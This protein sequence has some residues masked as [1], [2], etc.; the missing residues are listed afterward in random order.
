[1]SNAPFCPTGYGTVTSNICYRLL[2]EG[3]NVTTVNYWGHEG[4]VLTL[5]GLSQYPKAFGTFGDDAARFAIEDFKP[6]VFLTFFDVWVG[7]GWIDRL[8]PRWIPYMPVD[9]DPA[10]EGVVNLVRN[11]YR[12][13]AM[14][15]YAQEKLKQQAVETVYIPHGVD[16]KVYHPLTDKDEARTLVDQLSRKDKFQPRD[17]TPTFDKNCFVIGTNAMNKGPRKDYP[18]MALAIKHFLDQNPDAWNMGNRS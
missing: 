4:R 7:H 12:V 17:Q 6:H 16:T 14:S 2:K 5:N 11:A 15:L 8:H 13:V 1:M 3:F 9:H 10:P 18:R